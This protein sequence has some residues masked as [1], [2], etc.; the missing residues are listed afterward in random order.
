MN[1]KY[2]YRTAIA[3]SF[4]LFLFSCEKDNFDIKIDSKSN[5]RQVSSS[6][7][8]A[9]TNMLSNNFF[10]NEEGGAK[11][12]ST[13]ADENRNVG[14][15]QYIISDLGD[16]LLYAINFGN[17]NGYMLLSGD[18]GSFPI[19]AFVDSG[20]VYLNSLDVNSPLAG[21][22]N[23]KKEEIAKAIVEPIDTLNSNYQLWNGIG[24]DS[25]EVSIEFVKTIPQAQ[26]KSAGTRKHS[27]NKATVYPFTGS[28]YKWGQGTGYNFNA[29]ISGALAGCPSVAVGLLCFHHWYPNQFGYMYMPTSLPSSYNKQNAISLMF[30]EIGNQ[31]PNYHWGVKG[32]G[33]APNDILTGIK[34]LGYTNAVYTNY[35]FENAYTNLSNGNPVLLGA[36][37]NQ[38]SQGGHIWFCD[39]Y[40]EMSW[41]VTKYKKNIFGKKK[42][43]DEWFEYADYIY[44]NWG[45]NGTA[46][47]WYECNNWKATSGANLNYYKSMYVNLYPVN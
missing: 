41:K 37:Q 24:N 8:K 38:Y 28:H 17:D 23:E 40:Y 6:Q 45:W 19:I 33:A 3:F 47:G 7:A 32:S 9:F 5:S 16:T 2:L 29:P 1:L 18:K 27:T 4:M 12:K 10:T 42:K 21:W 35:N 11:L 30:R 26:L 20:S 22:L 15:M 46:D 14:N 44:M 31:I 13:K 25:C 39:G 43:V 34:R 36:F